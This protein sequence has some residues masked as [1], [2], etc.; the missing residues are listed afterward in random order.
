MSKSQR[1]GGN[2]L[3][4]Q[5]EIEYKGYTIK[6]NRQLFIQNYGNQKAVGH[7]IQ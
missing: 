4:K 6:I 3:K 2:L 5:Q 1:Q 7:Y